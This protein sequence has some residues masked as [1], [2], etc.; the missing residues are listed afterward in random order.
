MINKLNE[1]VIGNHNWIVYAIK[2][3]VMHD[4]YFVYVVEAIIKFNYLSPFLVE[5]NNYPSPFATLN[6]LISVGNTSS[7]R[8]H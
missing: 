2:T 1:L 4:F 6:R 8:K 3:Y 5:K 7:R